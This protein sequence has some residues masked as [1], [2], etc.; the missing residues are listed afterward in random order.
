MEK[1]KRKNVSI[2]DVAKLANLSTATVSRVLN[3]KDNVSEETR[4][5]IMLA[6]KELGY[7]FN[8]T[9]LHGNKSPFILLS[10]PTSN[11]LVYDSFITGV[12]DSVL[13]HNLVPVIMHSYK[14]REAEKRF[15]KIAIEENFC[16]AILVSPKTSSEDITEL[17][18]AMPVVQCFDSVPIPNG[19]IVQMDDEK[20]AYEATNYLITKGHRRIGLLKCDESSSSRIRQAGYIKALNDAKLPIDNRIIFDVPYEFSKSRDSVLKAFDQIELFDA[21][22]CVGTYMAYRVLWE[23]PQQ[24]ISIPNDLSI[25]GFDDIYLGEIFNPKLTIVVQNGYSIGYYAGISLINRQE[26]DATH[27]VG[28]ISNINYKIVERCSVKDV[29]GNK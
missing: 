3:N 19:T 4:R 5:K 13:R 17:A 9:P 27:N 24:N 15:Y 18:D 7:V 14:N 16:G 1:N 11:E 8:K 6:A 2:N 26:T 10:I 28:I 21:L 29:T 23:A 22:L 25:I 12:Y 20:A